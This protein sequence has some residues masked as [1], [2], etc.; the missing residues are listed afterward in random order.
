M[1]SFCGSVLNSEDMES[2]FIEVKS[3]ADLKFWLK[4]AK[5]AGTKAKLI[6]TEDWKIPGLLI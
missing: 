4:L 5:K 1:G 6:N 2:V 3:D